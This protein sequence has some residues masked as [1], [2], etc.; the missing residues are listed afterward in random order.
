M[1]YVA[2]IVLFRFYIQQPGIVLHFVQGLSSLLLPKGFLCRQVHIISAYPM[3]YSIMSQSTGTC[4]TAVHPPIFFPAQ[5]T[6]TGIHGP[7][8]SA[9]WTSI[10]RNIT[11]SIT[12]P[13]RPAGRTPTKSSRAAWRGMRVHFRVPFAAQAVERWQPHLRSI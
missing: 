8:C 11:R 12:S 5:S 10:T 1:S 6:S 3:P 13:T 7:R 9:C 4:C 2:P